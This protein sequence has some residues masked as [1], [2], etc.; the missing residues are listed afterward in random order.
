M[1]LLA[2]VANA[3][4]KMMS[5]HPLHNI[6][7]E[8]TTAV[9]RAMEQSESSVWPYCESFSSSAILQINTPRVVTF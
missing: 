7:G 8:I 2:F 6:H 5:L 4:P 3:S 1:F 9:L